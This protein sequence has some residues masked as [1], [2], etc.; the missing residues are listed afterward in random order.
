MK[1]FICIIALGLLACACQIPFSID[2]IS[3]PRFFVELIPAAGEDATTMKVAYAIPA[4]GEKPAAFYKLDTKDIHLEVNGKRIVAESLEWESRGESWK[5]VLPCRFAP[6][7]KVSVTLSEA[8]VPTASASTVIPEPPVIS[9][10]DISNIE[11]EDSDGRRVVVKLNRDVADGEYYGVEILLKEEMYFAKLTTGMPPAVLLDT[12]KYENYISPGQIASMADISNMDLDAFASVSYRY[13]GLLS[14]GDF[15]VLDEVVFSAYRPMSLLGARQFDGNSYSF[16]INADFNF[17][18]ML[19]G[20][21]FDMEPPTETSDGEGFPDHDEEPGDSEDPEEPGEYMFPLGSKTWYQIEVFRLS[22]ELYNY[23]KAQYLKD[24][25]ILS[26]FGV[27]PP[28]FTYSNVSGGLGI[29]GGISRC[30]TE[31]IPAPFNKEPEIPNL[32]DLLKEL[33]K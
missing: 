7:D 24:Y 1:Q 11:K 3:E 25:N 12:I 16:Y 17:G 8:N 19:G 22:D 9:S 31:L 32:W 28:N 2:N 30:K 23:C 6:G 27:T 5:T 29:V 21:N 26:N 33:S 13:G 14:E 18:D 10:V 15:Y 4:Y 20:T